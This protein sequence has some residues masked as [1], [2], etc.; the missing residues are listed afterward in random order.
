MQLGLAAIVTPISPA[1][2]QRVRGLYRPQHAA[3]SRGGTTTAAA[4][5]EIAEFCWL[6]HP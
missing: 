5:D 4:A 6:K 2:G 1:N 3:Q